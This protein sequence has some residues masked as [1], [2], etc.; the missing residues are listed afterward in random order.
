M[1]YFS[2]EEQAEIIHAIT[3]AEH[4]TSGE[5]R[6]AIEKRCVSTAMD[7]ATQY[8][9]RLGMHKTAQRNGVLIYLATEDH[10]FAIIGD[11]GINKKVPEHFWE[12]T[13][14]FMTEHFRNG[15]IVEG[16]IAGITNAGLQL[17]H[18]FPASMDDINELP[19]DILFGN[20]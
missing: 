1:G 5:I 14:G 3:L 19:N 8:F 18:Y 9:N 20:D 11:Q 2:E 6:V 7:R 4:K 13:K 17:S 12:D 10:M 16:I 15:N